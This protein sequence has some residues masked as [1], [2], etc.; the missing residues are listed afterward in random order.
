[1]EI[2]QPE[3][4]DSRKHEALRSLTETK[5]LATSIAKLSG[6]SRGVP[7][8]KDFHFYNNFQEFKNPVEDI[9]GKSKCM[10]QKIGES[11]NLYGKP[12]AFPGDKFDDDAVYDWLDNVNDQI[13][14]KI[15]AYLE[16]F[17]SL[18]N[19]TES[20]GSKGVFEVK[21]ASKAK[22]KIPFHVPTTPRPQDE[23]K[24]VVDNSNQ[25]FDHVSLQ[26]SDDGSRFI[27]PLVSY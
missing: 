23:Y 13:F 12:I 1:M 15:D 24:I 6:S 20:R 4:D 26:I 14:D 27:H 17:K 22:Q 3:E 9:D 19:K 2:D 21:V 25:P 8:Q 18:Q 11:E 16:E 5:G 7:S 10:L